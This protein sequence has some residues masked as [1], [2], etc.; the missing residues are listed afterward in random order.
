MKNNYLDKLFDFLEKKNKRIKKVR[1]LGKYLFFSIVSTITDILFLFILTEFFKIFYLI[2]A[3]IS[4]FIGLLISFFGNRKYTF[5]K[6]NNKKEFHKF[7]D[8]LLISIIDVLLTIILIKYLTETIGL[9]YIVSKI[10]VVI[11]IFFLK[12]FA[13]KKIAFKN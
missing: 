7:F 13:H 11:L 6:T 5:R 4:Y 10:I 9:W 1:T 8:F 2:S 12:F 3:I